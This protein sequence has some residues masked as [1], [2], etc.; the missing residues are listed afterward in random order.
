MILL[1][2][3]LSGLAAALDILL[4][5]LMLFVGVRVLISW[6]NP[7]PG[8]QIVRILVGFTEPFL[9]PLRR[10]IPAPG[11][12]DLSPILFFM[13]LAFINHALV[14]SMVDYASV[15]RLQALRP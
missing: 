10:Y 13:V 12:L 14:Q 9:A 15:L 5:L 1:A 6:V 11:G 8:N 7:D 3:I 2:N 4:T